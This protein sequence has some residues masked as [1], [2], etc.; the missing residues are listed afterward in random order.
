MELE[1]IE[2]NLLAYKNLEPGTFQHVDQITTERRTNQGLRNQWFYTADGELYTVQKRKHLWAITREPQNLVLENIDEAYRQL[3][4][5]GNYFPDA[6]AAQISLEHNDTVIVDIKG[7]ELVKTNNEYGHFIVN[8]KMI[9]KLN[10]QQ[11]M[12]AQRIYGPDEDNFEQNMKMFTKAGIKP[13]VYILMPEYIQETLKSNDQKF[14]G[15]ASWL[16]NFDYSSD[17]GAGGR[18]IYYHDRLRGVRRAEGV[19][20]KNE[21]MSAPQEIVTAPTIEDILTVSRQHVPEFG[22][23]NFQI[24]IG[25]LYK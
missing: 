19:A 20:E 14:I 13:N 10:S 12:V 4:G 5:Q 15:R 16:N 22:W 1:N 11:S 21:V 6:D 3:T 18:G 7:L 23:D 2:G 17:F 9:K 24:E 8:P 25:K